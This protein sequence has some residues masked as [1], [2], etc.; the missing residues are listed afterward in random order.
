MHGWEDKI[1]GTWM[2]LDMMHKA[3]AEMPDDL[4]PGT[5][6]QMCIG[7]NIGRVCWA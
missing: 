2:H 6:C 5:R 4:T 7:G 1:P 3:A